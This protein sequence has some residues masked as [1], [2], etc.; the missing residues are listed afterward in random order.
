[1][2]QMYDEAEPSLE[3]DDFLENPDD[4]PEDWYARHYLDSERQLEIMEEHTEDVEL[5]DSEHASLSLTCITSLGPTS[6][7]EVRDEHRQD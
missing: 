1:M 3:F 4:Y 2:N 5:T 7:K 6:S